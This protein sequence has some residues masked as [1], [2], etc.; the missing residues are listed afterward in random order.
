MG[1]ESRTGS[2]VRL[3]DG[4]LARLFD[5]PM[6]L[7]PD[8]RSSDSNFGR[9]A[10]DVTALPAGIPIHAMIGDSHAALFGHGVR[11]PG[12]AKATFGT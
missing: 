1:Q 7:L 4:E 10:A 9:L 6:A 12:A 2:E 8:V 11:T 5:V 3:G